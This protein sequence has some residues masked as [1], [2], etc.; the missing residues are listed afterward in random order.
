MN[1]N[2]TSDVI[3]PGQDWVVDFFRPDDAVG[4]AR[5][6]H[7]VYGDGYP[8]KTFTDPGRLIEE[9]ASGRT[10]SSVVRTVKGDIVGHNALF[11]SAPFNR[12]YEAGAGL[13]LP[14]YR[15]GFAGYRVVEHSLKVAPQKFDVEGVFGEPVCNHVRMQ[16]I[17]AKLGC[18]TCAV[19][20]D[21][22]PAEAYTKEASASGR[23]AALLDF[24]VINP[25]EQ[26]V[27]LPS[28]YAEFLRF[29][30]GPFDYGVRL[31]P[32][33]EELPTTL[34][35]SIDTRIF[36][37][38]RVARLAVHEAGSDIGQAIDE[39]EKSAKDKGVVVTQVWLKLSW[40]WIGHAVEQLR[41]RGYIFGGALPRWFDVD[42]LLMQK[43]IET[44][45]WDGIQVHGER[46]SR[47]LDMVK[48]DWDKR[49][50]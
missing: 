24:V 26:D 6:F 1:A 46:A 10:I 38:A 17:S 33:S 50:L 40:P 35:T 25:K 20:V 22:M 14:Q 16:K 9:N 19:E 3:E 44:P 45:D 49:A 47:I 5:L 43:F 41:S 28:P 31:K 18:I 36:D 48:T 27:Y 12:I 32:S 4:I 15:G 13:V 7:T 8:I 21:L 34:R 11:T 30:Y 2:T 42:G 37:F 39:E 23:V 29:I